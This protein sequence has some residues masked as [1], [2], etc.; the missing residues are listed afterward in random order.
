MLITSFWL[1]IPSQF[2]PVAGWNDYVKES[3]CNARES[4]L[5]WKSKY[6]H[7]FGPVCELMTKTR[8]R[9]KHCLHYCKSIEDKAKADAITRTFLPNDNISFWKDVKIIGKIG[10]DVLAPTVDDFTGEDNICQSGMIITV[11]VNC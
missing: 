9:F 6:K 10:S 5:M 11:T 3:H 4:F 7:R 2:K 8:A 1:K